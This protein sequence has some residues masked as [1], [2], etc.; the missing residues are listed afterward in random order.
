MEWRCRDETAHAGHAVCHKTQEVV[1]DLPPGKPLELHVAVRLRGALTPGVDSA[2]EVRFAGP[3]LEAQTLN[4]MDGE[5][6]EDAEACLDPFGT[7]RAGCLDCGCYG[8]FWRPGLEEQEDDSGRVGLNADPNSIKCIR[9]GDPLG[10]HTRAGTPAADRLLDSRPARKFLV[11]YTRVF[12]R[13]K[14]STTGDPIGAL[15]L[16]TEVSG[17]CE[18]RWLH[19]TRESAQVVNVMPKASMNS[20]SRYVDAWVLIDGSRIGIGSDLLVPEE[21]AAPD[22]QQR[23]QQEEDARQKRRDA[24]K[25]TQEKKAAAKKG[26]KEPKAE[27]DSEDEPSALKLQP[28]PGLQAL[29]TKPVDYLVMKPTLPIHK[30]PST[31]SRS[32]GSLKR[33]QIISG[34]PQESWLLLTEGGWILVDASPLGLG[35]QAQ[36]QQPELKELRPF[37]E[38]VVLEWTKFP[39][40]HVEYQVEWAEESE[41][42]QIKIPVQRE[43]MTMARVHDLPSDSRLL[44]RLTAKVLTTEGELVAEAIGCWEEAETGANIEKLE[45]GNLCSFAIKALE[46]AQVRLS[47]YLL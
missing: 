34:W 26:A 29:Y 27:P 28:R 18:G 39:A 17:C 22:L 40:K 19:L 11:A 2:P 41:K 12:V 1:S 15:R 30:R 31:S 47:R 13:S 24:V 6:D 8:F 9:C 32:I 33:G 5:D 16:G 4:P 21:L 25:K 35:L 3:W 20:S 38:A 14:R 44:F 43:T 37:S 42:D 23:A 7:A 36:A 10:T 46:V 45:E